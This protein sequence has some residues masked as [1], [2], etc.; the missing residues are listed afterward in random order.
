MKRVGRM[1]VGSWFWILLSL[2]PGCA[3]FSPVTP[4]SCAVAVPEASPVPNV[5]PS[6]DGSNGQQAVRVVAAAAAPSQVAPS[7]PNAPFEDMSELSVEAL[8][9]RVLARNPS[10][11]QMVAAW[12]AASA[13]YPQVTALED[14]MFGA[15]IGPGTIAPDDAGVNFAY[16]LEVS[17]KLP[18]PGKLKLRGANALAEAS[19]AGL[20]V[21]DMRLQLTESARNAF[22]EYYLVARALAVNRETR[23]RLDEFRAD[24]EALYKTPPRDR[25]V[26]LQEVVQARVEIGRQEE[27]QLTLERMWEVAVARINTLMH[28]PPDADLPPPPKELSPP[29]ALPDAQALRTIAVARRPDLEAIKNR[30]A[31]EQASL[32]LAHKEFYPD[33][34]PFFMYDRFMGNNS[35]SKDL[36]SMLGVRLNLPVY[37]NRRY[38]AV[39]EA[40]ARIAQRRAELDRQIDQVNLQ[41]QDAY[42]QMHES[43]RIVDL[44]KKKVLPDAELNVKTARADYMT[45]QIPAIS[46]IEAERN[47]LNLY[48]RYYEAVA[49]YFRRRATLERVTGG[50]IVP[51][52]QTST[53]EQPGNF[54]GVPGDQQPQP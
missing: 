50:P 54:P 3:E 47:R 37:R 51:F 49:D 11:T 5:R 45:G 19:A 24:A 6:Q 12:Q 9:Q 14:P 13:R 7:L 1:P 40:E 35:Q 15:T 31:A 4:C 44:Y 26:S 43:E 23:Q 8:V 41:V 17:Q 48:D 53:P 29:E 20:D 42:A 22:Y 16:R 46:V 25:K 33:F 38:G 36:A 27:R 34:E 39:A 21:D 18:Y 32:G 2:P 52:P 30:I 28:L 10:L